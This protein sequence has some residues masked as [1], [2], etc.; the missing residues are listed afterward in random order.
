MR[1]LCAAEL[2]SL[3]ERGA[4]RHALDRA[5][6]LVALTFSFAFAFGTVFALIW[7]RLAAPAA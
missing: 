1:V 4:P 6:L 7:N 2:L 5:A 3:W